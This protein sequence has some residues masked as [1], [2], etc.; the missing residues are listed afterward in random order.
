MLSEV[1][2]TLL[3]LVALV[4]LLAAIFFIV[5]KFKP[6]W[7]STDV[8]LLLAFLLLI[9]MGTSVLNIWAHRNK[10]LVN[11][12]IATQV[13][14]LLF[15]LILLYFL[16]SSNPEEANIVVVNFFIIYLVLLIFE[17]STLLSN[18]RAEFTKPE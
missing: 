1:L 11:S 2:R 7:V 18:L 14:R 4:L 8:N 3:K 10:M 16:I 9:T 6:T 5:G 13:I 12:F 17:I 15:C